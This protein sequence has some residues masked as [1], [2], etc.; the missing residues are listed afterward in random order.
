MHGL[1]YIWEYLKNVTSQK[2]RANEK[3]RLLVTNPYKKNA[4]KTKKRLTGFSG[5][6]FR[7]LGAIR[8]IANEGQ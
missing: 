2:V 5:A 1:F 8:K 4:K 3:H 6:H 7:S